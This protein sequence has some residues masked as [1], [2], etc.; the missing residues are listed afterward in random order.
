MK[1]T[2]LLLS[3]LALSTTAVKAS[4][5]NTSLCSEG[6]TPAECKAYISGLVEGYVASKQNY[7]PKQPVFESEY[8]ERAF[9]NRVGKSY[10][11]LNNKEPACLPAVVN[12]EQIVAHLM[13][14][15]AQQGLTEQLGQYLRA[16]YSCNDKLAKE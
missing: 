5:T 13:N 10:S 12:K 3:A 4:D 14:S 6:K 15:N 2:I 1:P 11:T 9:A 7:L 8:L 16:N